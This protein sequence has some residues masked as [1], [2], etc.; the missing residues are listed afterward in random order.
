[1]ANN[2]I[3]FEIQLDEQNNKLLRP[4]MKVDVYVV[5]AA[6]TR[7]MRVANGAAFKGPSDQD[8]FVIRNGKA[9]RRRLHIGLSNFDYV[10]ILDGV[11][12]G[13]TIITSDMSDYLHAEEVTIKN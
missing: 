2:V 9:E 11:K 6:H 8:V 1:V 12:P 10:E 3:S 7:V 5:T 13:E 4:N